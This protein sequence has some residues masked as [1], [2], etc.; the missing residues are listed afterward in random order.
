VTSAC[1]PSK[2]RSHC[3][4]SFAKGSGSQAARFRHR[5]QKPRPRH[6]RKPDRG[7]GGAFGRAQFG[8]LWTAVGSLS[9][10]QK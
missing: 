5:Q 1:F 8:R 3:C 9:S 10:R 2:F 4:A 7:T 6:Y